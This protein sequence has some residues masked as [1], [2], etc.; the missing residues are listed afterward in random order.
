ML[1]ITITWIT[2]IR[3]SSQFAVVDHHQ[4][5]IAANAYK[6]SFV[7]QVMITPR[8]KEAFTVSAQTIP[9][10]QPVPLLANPVCKLQ[11]ANIHIFLLNSLK[12]DPLLTPSPTTW[13][14]LLGSTTTIAKPNNILKISI[15]SALKIHVS[16]VW[17]PNF[18]SSA[19]LGI[20]LWIL[21]IN[22]VNKDNEKHSKSQHQPLRNT[23]LDICSQPDAIP[24]TL[25]STCN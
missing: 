14:N 20:V 4:Q 15:K 24:S 22:I 18:V 6:Y 25:P 5:G 16:R 9:S 7:P 11:L 13:K 21:L 17:R 3:P 12:K 23:P 19:N 1:Y 2:W 8:L 10:P